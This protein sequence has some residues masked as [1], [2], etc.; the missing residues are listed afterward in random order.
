M[1]DYK[2]YEKNGPASTAK[3]FAQ[4]WETSKE[5][6][7]LLRSGVPEVKLLCP[8]IGGSRP[9][10]CLVHRKYCTIDDHWCTIHILIVRTKWPHQSG[11]NT[12]SRHQICE[13]AYVLLVSIMLFFDILTIHFAFWLLNDQDRIKL[14]PTSGIDVMS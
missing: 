5:W 12:V 14:Y 9:F 1:C 3:L 11:P 8:K 13:M 7:L 4:A 2:I 10:I 6:W